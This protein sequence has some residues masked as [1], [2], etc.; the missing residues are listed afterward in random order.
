MKKTLRAT[1]LVD[2][3]PHGDLEG[4]WGLSIYI[5]YGK[6]RI[7]LD[8]GDSDMFLRNGQKLGIDISDVDYSVLSHAHYD[9]SGGTETFFKV[10][11]RA[12]LYVSAGADANCYSREPEGIKY[13]GIPGE[14]F[15]KNRSRI[16]Y[17]EDNF[18]PSV[19]VWVIPHSTP[20]MDVIG[21]ENGMLL[22]KG[23]E[24]VDD[25][26]S[27][28]QSLVFETDKGLVIF[29]SCSHGGAD[30]IAGEVKKVLP[31]KDIYVYIGGLHLYEKTEEEVRDTVEILKSLGI[32]EIYTGHCTGEKACA[33]IQEEMGDSVRIFHS[34]MVI[35]I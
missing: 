16:K 1:L 22:K 9:H 2:N 25:D 6:K 20:G 12:P 33:I 15:E 19:G 23:D 34:G 29:N 3:T 26:F 7:L 30:L 17:V 27:H 14:V 32:K 21:K 10:N 13:I 35:N 28:E 5:E 31:R 24:Y 11:K 4:E 18:S 8:N